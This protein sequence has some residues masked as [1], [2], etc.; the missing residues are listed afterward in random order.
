MDSDVIVSAFVVAR[1]DTAR[2]SVAM[3]EP[4]WISVPA[5][6]ARPPTSAVDGRNDRP[7][8]RIAGLLFILA[9]WTRAL[10]PTVLTV[11]F[12]LSRAVF[13]WGAPAA[14]DVEVPVA[15]ARAAAEL[16]SDKFKTRDPTRTTPLSSDDADTRDVTPRATP[17]DSFAVA[18]WDAFWTDCVIVARDAF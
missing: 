18:V 9:A 16:L 2:A 7:A 6:V 1:A 13:V 15:V 4:V 12:K 8:R 3:F 14:R 5:I 10:R 11:A 17:P